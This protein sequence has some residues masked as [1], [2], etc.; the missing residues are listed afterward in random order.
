MSERSE[1]WRRATRPPRDGEAERSRSTSPA[2]KTT[3]QQLRH[4]KARHGSAGKAP[5]NRMR[6]TGQPPVDRIVRV[7]LPQPLSP[8]RRRHD[9]F[10]PSAPSSLR[11]TVPHLP[12]P[13]TDPS[14][15]D[16]E[17]AT[18]AVASS[19]VLLRR[20]K[21]GRRPQRPGNQ[22]ALSRVVWMFP[23]A[24]RSRESPAAAGSAA[25]IRPSQ[26]PSRFAEPTLRHFV[27]PGNTKNARHCAETVDVETSLWK[28][29]EI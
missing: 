7:F 13:V 8:R 12:K 1:V 26:E 11:T 21:L 16:H 24:I 4:R 29:L 14:S 20:A 18:V 17:P 9:R 6:P 19:P 28:P 23:P 25:I 5:K 15:R 10:S 22:F 2:T 27:A 3:N